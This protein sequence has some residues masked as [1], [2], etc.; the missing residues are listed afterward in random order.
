MNYCYVLLAT[1]SVCVPVCA[2]LGGMSKFWFYVKNSLY[3]VKK[4]KLGTT[5]QES[6]AT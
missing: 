3:M 6:V 4:K 1:N 2:W 5:G